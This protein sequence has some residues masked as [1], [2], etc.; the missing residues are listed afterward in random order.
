MGSIVSFFLV[1]FA[2]LL[3][4]LVVVLSTEIF[5]AVI[6]PR[7]DNILPSRDQINRRV[8][9]LVPA[10][11]ESTGLL[12][13]LADIKGQLRSGNR[14]LVVA[15]NCSDDTAAVARAAGAEV[16]ERSNPLR[17]GKGYAL[18]WGLQYLS[19]DPPDI[20]VMI[21][22]DCTLAGDTLDRLTSACAA[23][24]RP[25]QALDL[26]T[27][28]TQSPIDY[29]VAEFAFRV[30]NWVR[31]LGL[32]ALN[33]PCQ[34]MGTGMAFPWK[35]M[36]SVNLESGCA[37]EDLKLGL[38]LARAGYPAKFYPLACVTSQFPSSAVGARSQ[39]QR[40]EHGHLSAI[41]TTIPRIA[42]ESL[43]RRDLP[44][45]ALAL[46][47]AVP[48]LILLGVLLGA[49]VAISALGVLF[50]LSHLSLI[51]SAGALSLYLI[52]LLVCW[53]KFGRDILPPRAILPMVSYVF[54]K[55]PLY[56]QFVARGSAS[57][58]T[59][60]DRSTIREDAK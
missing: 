52:S 57:K 17:V 4:V 50:G 40:W 26:M 36:R 19:A 60:T 43:V 12:K 34:L 59:R 30:K 39:R 54:D 20:V 46:D 58:W 15:D 32:Q 56:R 6:L 48:P 22:A 55:L 1:S 16:T 42:F 3:A 27:A 21:D 45:F 8:A 53:L 24:S 28:S 38:D 31:P 33:L 35:L 25:I 2:G 10:H 47:A 41:T 5:A 37:V 9:V 23:T 11:D 13:T 14:L 44:L 18:A 49:A 51:L 29:R 7:R